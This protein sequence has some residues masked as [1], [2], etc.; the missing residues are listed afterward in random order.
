MKTVS[1]SLLVLLL[2]TTAGAVADPD[3]DLIGLSFDPDGDSEC[4]FAVGP[5]QLKLY[6]ILYNPTATAID[7]YEFTM[8]IEFRPALD[9][10]L[11]ILDSLIAD[12][13]AQGVDV[14]DKDNA[15]EPECIVGL[16][17]PLPG[18]IVVVLHSWEILMNGSYLVDLFLGPA[19]PASL[20]GGLPIVQEAGGDLM[21]VWTRRQPS[22][23]QAMIN[24]CPPTATEST[25]FGTLKALYR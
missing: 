21:T 23:V 14:G 4:A 12:G 19:V 18:G 9:G 20:P 2:A 17:T 16:A 15:M 6:C 3:P 25:T 22:D 8:K 11:Y 10:Y 7:A 24:E 13:Q 1:I 5:T